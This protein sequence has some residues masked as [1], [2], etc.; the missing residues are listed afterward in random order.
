MQRLVWK[1]ILKHTYFNLDS[2]AAQL[3]VGMLYQSKQ[4]MKIK[5]PPK[6][7]ETSGAFD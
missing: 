3:V 2:N 6:P 1:Y 7:S 4:I 5:A